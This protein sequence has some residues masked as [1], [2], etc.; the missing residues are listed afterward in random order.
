MG[1]GRGY[2]RGYGLGNDNN[3]FK[4]PINS[5]DRALSTFDHTQTQQEIK[6]EETFDINSNE[7]F[8]HYNIYLYI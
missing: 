5:L 7:D 2:G 3:L 6:V 1:R 8:L 4:P